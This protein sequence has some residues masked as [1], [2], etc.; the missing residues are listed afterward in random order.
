MLNVVPNS[1]ATILTISHPNLTTSVDLL[2][3]EVAV[4]CANSLSP[5]NFIS[6]VPSIV[7]NSFT[8]TV[9]NIFPTNTPVRFPD[10]VYYWKITF[11]Y[12]LGK[13]DYQ[14]VST[15]CMFID[16]NIK[17]T[18]D[19]EDEEFMK[20]YKALQYATDCDSCTCTTLCNLFS[21]LTNTTIDHG[22]GCSG[23]D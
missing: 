13:D 7:N 23:C 11:K 18:I 17:C 16:Y 14:Y 21:S 15:K 4:D 3:L 20:K 9:A 8:V 19:I 5:F 1:D 12:P 10:G 6:K 22:S 2:T